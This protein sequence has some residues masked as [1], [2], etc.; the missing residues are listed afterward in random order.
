MLTLWKENLGYVG[1]QGALK[2]FESWI[3]AKLQIHLNTELLAHEIPSKEVRFPGWAVWREGIYRHP[4]LNLVS[5]R[6]QSSRKD[7]ALSRFA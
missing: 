4:K 2:K 3:F 6:S 1:S 5:P 7:V